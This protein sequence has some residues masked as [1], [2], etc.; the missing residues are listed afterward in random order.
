MA[1][2]TFPDIP[3]QE[4]RIDVVMPNVI[5]HSSIYTAKEQIFSRGN[6][7]YQGRIGWSRR[8]VFDRE[9]EVLKIEAFFAE[10]S[11][12]VNTFKVPVPGDQTDRFDNSNA[13]VI[14][15]V[16]TNGTFDSEF[17]ATAGLKVGDWV[18]FGD[19]LHKIVVAN[20]TS[21]KVVP[22][23]LNAETSMAWHSPMLLARLNVDTVDL[24]RQG[25]WA[26]PWTEE[27]TEVL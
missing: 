13:L 16:T 25:R 15:A 26:G 27:I 2:I 9:D 1:L 10:C 23:I 18:N 22:G 14:S 8:S 6:M 3:L 24:I 5:R 20:N 12:P 11:G 17:T 21:Y 4:F 19:R 7:Y